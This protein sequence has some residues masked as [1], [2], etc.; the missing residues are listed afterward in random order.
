MCGNVLYVT[1]WE[2]YSCGLVFRFS[3]GEQKPLTVVDSAS[4]KSQP[5]CAPAAW[6][7]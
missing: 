4:F 7:Q 2:L 6:K 5:D 1:K 3:A